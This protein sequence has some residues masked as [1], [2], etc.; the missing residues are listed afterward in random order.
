M[1]KASLFFKIALLILLIFVVPAGFYINYKV[2]LLKENT[3][4]KLSD[5][6]IHNLN[7]E[8]QLIK[9]N[10]IINAFF[11]SDSDEIRNAL[12]NNDRDRAIKVLQE[13]YKKFK[14]STRIKDLKVHIHTADVRSFIRSWKLEKFGDKLSDFR[15]TIVR[16][17]ET[18][19]PVFNYEVG[20][21][22]LTLRS[23][24]PILKKDRYLGSL[25]FIESFHN[26]SK[27]FVARGRNHLLLMNKSL[28]NIAVDLKNA[29]DVGNYKLS[30]DALNENFLKEA[31]KL[32][33][34]KLKKEGYVL[35]DQYL[36]TYK[37]IKDIE[38]H[39]V[40]IHLLAMPVK[41]VDMVV[42]GAE[43][44]LLIM[45]SI[46]VGL[47]LFVLILLILLKIEYIERKFNN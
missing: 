4:A 31:Q 6:L 37:Q 21:M 8:E 43:R 20:R 23:I 1:K 22:G 34:N 46:I 26:A 39:D 42:N 2:E 38:N 15:N 18:K 40:G 17:K 24:V 10:G 44:S 5:E 33:F 12:I 3:Y 13:T 41:E 29:A 32:N 35:T 16:V 25:E 14:K 7:N 27:S 45:T 47:F 19:E 36:F 30:L 28:L 9:N 11:I